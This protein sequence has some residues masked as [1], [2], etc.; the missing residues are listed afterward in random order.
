[1][2]SPTNRHGSAFT[3]VLTTLF[4]TRRGICLISGTILVLYLVFFSSS[5]TTPS[6]TRPTDA[7]TGVRG[8]AKGY[9]QDVTGGTS[10]EEPSLGDLRLLKEQRQREQQRLRGETDHQDEPATSWQKVEQQEEETEHKVDLSTWEEEVN[11]RGNERESDYEPAVGYEEGERRI[12]AP[13]DQDSSSDDR[14]HVNVQEVALADS[15]R[16]ANE[17]DAVD[18]APLAA[19]GTTSSSTEEKDDD[20]STNPLPPNVHLNDHAAAKV[21]SKDGHR[22]SD[23]DS[24]PQNER[25]G[26]NAKKP[27]PKPKNVAAGKPKKIGTGGKVVKPEQVL[28]AADAA[29]AAEEGTSGGGEKAG[30]VVQAEAGKR[31]GTGA[32]PG[33]KGMGLDRTDMFGTGERLRLRRRRRQENWKRSKGTRW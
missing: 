4:T 20:R 6:T 27:K 5:T 25:I 10:R 31:V 2:P 23:Q 28:A 21:P 22:S 16:V 19:L 9:W 1:M 29:A 7:T 12:F 32:R 17:Q 24:K 14:H 3:V 13:N 33:A 18:R 15:P 8:W 11:D 30:K 26:G